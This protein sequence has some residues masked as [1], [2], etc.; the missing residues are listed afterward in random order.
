MKRI[1]ACLCL[2][3]SFVAVLPQLSLAQD[4][5]MPA[6]LSAANTRV[7]INSATAETLALAL[8]GIGLTKAADIVAYREE[9]GSFKSVDELAL[10]KGV[11]PATISRNREKIVL[12]STPNK[13]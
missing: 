10:V 13:R 6:E 2:C 11:G 5:N 12:E 1:F 4:S 9:H 3:C 7:D 8:D